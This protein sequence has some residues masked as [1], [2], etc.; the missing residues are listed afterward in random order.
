MHQIT[1]SDVLVDV[2]RKDIKN[3][4]LAVY[5]PDGRVRIAAPLHITDDSIRLAVIDKLAWVKTQQEK[6][7]LQYRQTERQYI[8]G[9][10][11]FFKGQ[12]YLLKV[13]NKDQVPSVNIQAGKL[14]L[15]VRPES[16]LERR[17]R[18]LTEWYRDELK[19][20]IPPFIDKW[21]PRLDVTVNEWRVKR[22]K[23]KW[24]TC[25]AHAGRIWLNLELVKKPFHVW[26]TS[27]YMRWFIF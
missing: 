18:V 23:T 25:T 3:L 10:S 16:D 11:H 5:P 6:F 27:W 19:Q 1:V 20:I 17:R 4:H 7:R 21:E 22:M 2:V 24:G 14:I 13:V 26:N 9:E 8:S 15:T 12:R